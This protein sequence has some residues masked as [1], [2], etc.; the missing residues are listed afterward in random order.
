MMCKPMS[1]AKRLL[2]CALIAFAVT[3]PAYGDVT[4]ISNVPLATSSSATVLPN[5]LF[6]LDSSGSMDWD[7][8]PDYVN[9]SKKC[10]N[11]S[12]NSTTC[13]RGDPPFEAGGQFGFNGVAYD[14][15]VNYLPALK[16]D[17]TTVL[18]APLTITAVPQDAYQAQSTSTTDITSAITDKQFCNSAA[19]PVCKR[20][21][22]NSAGSSLVSGADAA[23]HT[24]SAGQFPYRTN[25]AN[26]STAIF[27][28]P[29]MMSIG[30][31]VRSGSTVTVTTLETHGLTTSNTVFVTGI[32]SV[33]VTC[34]AVTAATPYT[35]T[36]TSGTSGT[37]SATTGSY[38]R[39]VS[40]NFI[41]ALSAVTVASTAH[42]LVTND[43]I[44]TVSSNSA[45][46]VSSAAVTVVDANTFIYTASSSGII[47][48]TAGTWVR[49]GIYNNA[50]GVSGPAM[51]YYI[52]PVEYCSNVNLTSCV[53]VIPPATP[54]A[55]YYP[56]YVRFCQTQVQ[57][58]APGA[59][60]GNDAGGNALCLG[61]Y[62]SS[63][64]MAVTYNYPRFGWFTRDTIQSS[65]A[66]YAR[67]P[68]RSDCSVAG[69]V[70]TCTYTQEI[71]NYARWFAY[72]QTRM[73]MMKTAA[74][75]AFLGFVS[76]A[77]ATPPRAD[78][79]RVGFITINPFYNM[80]GSSQSTVQSSKYL[81]IDNFN[82]TQALNWYT[83][84]Y[85]QVPSQSTPLR[86]AIARAGWIFAGQLN[87]GLTAGIP[88]T[89]DPVQ[90][91]C[92][93]NFTLMTTDGFWNG[94]AGQ[95]LGA[96]AI[97]NYDDVDPT[98]I[99]PYTQPTVDR[100]TT[101]TFDGG[102]AVTTTNTP[103][104]TTTEQNICIGS[105]NTTFS[106][107]PQT[108]CGC[109]SGEQ[110]II[111]RDVATG[112]IVVS[113]QGVVTSTSTGTTT[114]FS[115]VTACSLQST[116]TTTTPTTIVEQQIV[117]GTATTTFSAVNGVTAGDNKPGTCPAGQQRIKQRTTTST[118]TSVTTNGVSAPATT[119]TNYAFTDVGSCVAPQV[120]TVTTPINLVEEQKVVGT[121]T[122]TF[123]TITGVTGS[124]NAPGTCLLA[125]QERIRRRTTN[126]TTKVVTTDGVSAPATNSGGPYTPTDVG[127]C[128]APLVATAN[129]PVT[130]VEQQ[131]LVANATSTFAAIGGI[132]S[133]A[134]QA[135]VCAANF[136]RIKQRTTTYTSR[137]VTT[138]GAAAPA[139]I[140]GGSVSYNLSDPG[141]C[142][143]LTTTAIY[144]V[145]E[146][147]QYVGT[148]T[149]SGNNLNTAFSAAAN[150]DNTQ[151]TFAC[152]SG[153]K[154]LL[155]RVLGYSDTQNTV[156]AGAPT[157]SRSATNSGPSFS[158]VT[159]CTNGSL[160]AAATV[161]SPTLIS[162]TSTGG[163]TAAATTTTNGS[164][165]TSSTGG[166]TPVPAATTTTPGATTT[167]STG[168]PTPVPVATTT[169][170][171]AT[172]T[173]SSGSILT[174]PLSPNPKTTLG[175]A[176][177][178]VTT[179]GGT[180][181]TLA[182]TALYYYQTD[183]RGGVDLN[184]DPTGP[185]MNLGGTGSVDVSANDMPARS[186]AKDFVTHQHMVTFTVG[187][188]DGLMKYQPDYDTATNGDFFNIKQKTVGACF[189]T[190][191]YCDWPA[192]V[193]DDSTA[194]DDLWHAAVN[195]RG[196]FYQAVNVTQLS[197]GLQSALTTLTV[198]VAAAAASA[199]S[200]PNVTQTDNQIFSTTYE[201]VT[202][203]GKVFAQTIDPVT[204]IV[205]AA[206]QWDA[207]TLLLNQVSTASDT[208]NL[209]MR[210]VAA[211]SGSMLKSFGWT[212]L[213]AAEQAWFSNKCT[214][215]TNMTQ[216][217]S[218]ATPPLTPAQLANAN[219][220]S[221][222]VGYL[223][224]WQNGEG[225]SFRDRMVIDPATNQTAN[226]VL[227][228]TISARPAYVRAP[229]FNYGDLVSPSYASFQS[230]NAGRA[231]RVYVAANDGYL[232]A[233]DA[234][235]GGGNEVWAYAPRFLLPGLWQLADRGY[236]AK[237][238]F[239]V[240][241][242]PET[243]DVYD[244]SAGN[245]KTILV[246]GAS[247]GGRGFYALD[248]T[249]PSNPKSLWEFCSDSTLCSISDSDLGFSYGNPVIGKRKVDG[250]WVVVLTSGLNNVSPGTGQGYFYLLDA[251]SGAVLSKVSTGAGSTT[252]PSGLMKIAAYFD[253]ALTDATF[254]YLYGGDQLG[255]VWR[256]DV[257]TA[258]PTVLHIATLKDGSATPLPQPIT[259][260]P[261]L[262]HIGSDRIIYIGTGRYLGDTDLSDHTASGTAWQQSLYAFKDQNSDYGTNLRADT[263]MVK[264]FL[265]S[266]SPTERGVSSN[267]VDWTQKDGWMMDFNPVFAGVG[268]S[269]GEAVNIDPRLV[270]GTLVVITN[271]PN[272]GGACAI[273][274]S[275]FEYNFDFKTGN[276]LSN[277]TNG[278]VGKSL[279]GT[280][281]VGMA[282][283]QLPSGAIKDIVTGADTS[284]T[285]T[286]VIIGTGTN[287]AKRFSY[288]RR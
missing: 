90:Q 145:T 231:P 87:T 12:G 286:D 216:C 34:A 80:S 86:T 164:T 235:A 46:N 204:G 244:A 127:S 109:A 230:T 129:T 27:G 107:S 277:S 11:T 262:T 1:T 213:S 173:T 246:G 219:D 198:Q 55:G 38:R 221:L 190:P 254:Q 58:L 95:T 163:P 61:K 48:S 122:T 14:P 287:A 157:H 89:D 7:Y 36:Y 16:S 225:T 53:E 91:S 57:A 241:G 283:V 139:T 210:D 233:F 99:A 179:P 276:A 23:G 274:G 8:L 187:M 285:T 140:V 247:D 84:F 156:G 83:K 56:A 6:T 98:I 52:T 168:G 205:N 236:A 202:W 151:A 88:A 115:N 35:F 45:F 153:R 75:R 261:V 178:T 59:V 66:S 167:T 78:S 49:N 161:V 148:G 252:T 259:T 64:A 104:S 132:T 40:G 248:I 243:G 224:G 29:E 203:S 195:G 250:K 223:R 273:G 50:S 116:V 79:L 253:S 192:P 146:T 54:P 275:S 51:S 279:G 137:V 134:N 271:A 97:G 281:A 120:V 138:D 265:S 20:N 72:Y 76:N 62:V 172:T 206:H 2:A 183:L 108:A 176:P 158:T 69:S 131:M 9:D 159:N 25:A 144:S 220:G 272:A 110:Q 121:A 193:A 39:C 174:I 237:H 284:K 217:P 32:A 24:L 136:G 169:T 150:G 238:T 73:Q 152:Q 263:N 19:T 119:S 278:V 85:A 102:G 226:T 171:G 199:T 270:L 44:T 208:R 227:G 175:G 191:G 229:F 26:A 42:G 133:G 82:T 4:H 218:T 177:L 47:A 143:A 41:R 93:R 28:L 149:G 209:W 30:S 43:V 160:T 239:F 67:G 111:Q 201:T 264:Q 141:S 266:I 5:L 256:L 215:S 31:F 234:S 280:I 214:P 154:T 186:G 37:V 103:S 212:V 3:A 21:G 240:D 142:V 282:I 260:K 114:A 124:A 94:T 13:G 71:Q 22:A 166:P 96:K 222:M 255:N 128:V 188:A 182:D 101:G 194:L 211:A 113:T 165:T 269:P 60:T 105:N 81:R 180:G 125:G 92:Q 15:N 258:T 10:M 189:W 126:Y 17:G 181:D 135:G 200:S 196:N 130:L 268:N 118:Q 70:S 288:R 117:V 65:V 245:W 106:T 155:Q 162:S 232:H 63:S 170:V 68:N 100:A 112:S 184:G 185:S 197:Q 228:D 207:D 33:N 242:S 249:D 18:S 77:S 123:S 251:I 267:P 74:G 147:A 257:S